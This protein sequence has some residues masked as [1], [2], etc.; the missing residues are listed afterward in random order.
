M[1]DNDAGFHGRPIG[2]DELKDLECFRDLDPRAIKNCNEKVTCWECKPGQVIC[3]QGQGG[4][5]AFYIVKGRV[6]VF[7]EKRS[8]Q[9]GSRQPKRT[10]LIA[11]IGR[12]FSNK[13]LQTQGRHRDDKVVPIDASV[14][15]TYG[16]LAAALGP[17]DIFGEMSCLSI[18]PR[19]ATV[20]AET[21]CVLVE[22]LR[23]VYELLQKSPAFKKQ[24]DEKY[25]ARAL[26]SHLKN[27]PIFEALSPEHLD[28]LRHNA[29]LATHEPGQVI[30]HEGD[31]ADD[32][33]TGGLYLLRLGQVKVSI[34]S[35]GGERTL[36]YLTKGDCF[37][38]IGLLRGAQRTATCTAF[39]HPFADET[40]RKRRT[41]QVELVRIR[42]ADFKDLIEKY[43]K[44]R[45]RLEQLATPRIR[46]QSPVKPIVPSKR[47][48]EL[49][50]I[51]GQNL[52]L[53]DLTRCTR[54]DQCVDACVDA[55][56]DG[57]TRL[58]REGPR[59]DRF[60]VPSSCRMCMDPVC[61]IGCPVASIRRAP[62]LHIFIEPWCIGC[63][64]CAKQCP[65]DS[66]QMH[67]LGEYLDADLA[68]N[69]LKDKPQDK[70]KPKDKSLA[71]V[72]DQC[73]SL[74]TGPACVYA[75]PH[76]AAVR[77]NAREFLAGKSPTVS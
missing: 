40:G 2:P 41:S 12:L 73:S 50:L 4:T 15:L 61:M 16:N 23:N 31:A 38:E 24:S 66:I 7:I 34:K 9:P 62:D 54:C 46:D 74:P 8:E 48:E 14:D 65:Y 49:G 57:V 44:I 33:K 77:V 10:G 42:P 53:I 56:N 59:F 26:E 1:I 36:A 71:V 58:I 28:H 35:P 67:K 18:A 69:G 75:C 13:S 25:R 68:A 76:D 45:G 60:L 30:F 63:E 52:M 6:R 27:L 72:C 70:G 55:H 21:D 22:M 37:G 51:Q 3:E 29:E 47:A 43:P 5:T 20:V 32:E 19:S 17:G 39:D 11:K 64:V